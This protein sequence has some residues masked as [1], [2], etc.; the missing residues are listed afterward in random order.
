MTQLGVDYSYGRPG[1]AALKA[2]GKTFAVRY[3][4]PGDGRSL[5]KTELAD[6]LAHDISVPLVWESVANRALGGEVDGIAD[7]KAAKAAKAALGIGASVPVYFAVD[8]NAATT[9]LPTIDAYL[10]GVAQ[11]LGGDLV[12][13]YGGLRVIRHCQSA[14][15]A[16]WFWQTYAWS[17][18]P[19]IWQPNTHMQQY[20]NGQSINGADVD[21]D[22][23]LVPNFGQWPQPLPDS[24]TGADMPALAPTPD[25]IHYVVDVAAGGTAYYDLET[26]QVAIAVMDKPFVGVTTL[27]TGVRPSDGK[28][29]RDIRVQLVSGGPV[30]QMWVGVDKCSNLRVV[31]LPA[32]TATPFSQADVDAKVA[33]Q[34]TADAATVSAAQ[35]AAATAQAAAT[36]AQASLATANA[37]ITALNAKIAKAKTDLA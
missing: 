15:S 2:A 23:A 37:Q 30:Y 33:A 9:D 34:K 14:G 31:N 32:D 6:L 18:T 10:G 36:A 8:F 29:L 12:G 21:L 16:K 7:G 28:V 26:T 35:A 17:G 25:P 27:G 3:L 19:T 11:G 5:T 13:V 22:R 24:S 1:G 20:L 4:Q